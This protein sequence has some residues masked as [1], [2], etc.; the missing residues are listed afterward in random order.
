VAC[1]GKLPSGALMQTP[2]TD[3]KDAVS[4][5][6]NGGVL[7][8]AGTAFLSRS[9]GSM[10]LIV[11]DGAAAIGVGTGTVEQFVPAGAQAT[12]TDAVSMPV[13]YNAAGIAALPTNNLPRRFQVTAPLSQAAIEA[14]ITALTQPTPT[15]IVPTATP[16]DVCRRTIGRDTTV[17]SGPGSNFEAL[18]TLAAGTA[19]TP[20]FTTTNAAGEV[21]WQ[22][23]DSGWVAR[24]VVVERGS[25]PNVPD[26][27]RIPAPPSNT[28]SLEKCASTNGPVRVG[29]QVTFEFVPPAWDN[30]G[31]ALSATQTDPG[32]FT[33]NSD[34]YGA[35]V[36]API[37]LGT[38]VAPNEDRY[39]RRFTLV[40]TAQAG[41]YRV[42]GDWLHYEP[43]CNLTVPA[44]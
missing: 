9:A 15:P 27:G 31:E 2:S 6:I 33:L 37:K 40:W 32:H 21:W 38:K 10:T 36:S 26:A 41:T 4:L 16:S 12:V 18:T 34:H 25:C 29:Q 35:Y 43:I 30:L 3:F 44:E 14:A 11:L 19:I 8:L 39:V 13:P 28:Y 17:S 7:R 5:T 24:S 20:V 1:D 42:E 22:L 23:N